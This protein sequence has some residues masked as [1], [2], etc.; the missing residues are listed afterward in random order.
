M[1]S[2][3]IDHALCG[4]AVAC[5]L[6]ASCGAVI[7]LQP[8]SALLGRYQL[9]ADAAALP[10]AYGLLSAATVAAMLK[11]RPMPC[12]EHPMDSPAAT[13][14]KLI[15]VLCRLGQGALGWCTPFFMQPALD[16]LF[17]ARVGSQLAFG[18]AID[19]P[20][21][22]SIGDRVVLGNASL[23]TGNYL[24][25]GMLVCHPVRIGADVTIGANA[26]VMPGSTVGE[27]A[28]VVSGSVVMPGT[29]IPAGETWRGNPARKWL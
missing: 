26:I 18:G 5:V 15:T 24:S 1:K 3:W 22:V 8:L 6:A 27:R 12:G 2:N 20:Y 29:S 7:A 28:V 21:L 11:L 9:L 4:I 19:D 23:V 16:A 10:I 25:G 14:W 17:G 13:Y